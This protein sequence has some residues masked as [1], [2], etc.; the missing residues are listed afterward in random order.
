MVHSSGVRSLGVRSL[1]V[2]ILGAAAVIAASLSASPVVLAQGST[3]K[4]SGSGWFVPGAGA[5]GASG[6]SSRRV[7]EGHS[8]RS[9]AAEQA[10]AGQ[11][12][13]GQAGDGAPQTPPVLPLPP[14]PALPAM[15]KGTAPPSAV[16]GVLSVQDVMRASTA[17]QEVQRVL[18]ARRDKLNQEAEQEQAGWR[19]TQQQIQDSR[20][21]EAQKQKRERALQQRVL[22]AQR[23]FRNRNRILQEAAQV[24]LGQVE[25]EL[26]QVIR[27]VAEARGMNLVLHREQVALNVNGFD[28]TEQV[29]GQL[30]A[31]LNS[32]FIPGPG[33]DPE[34]MAKSGAFPTTVN[35][36]PQ[37]AA[38]MIAQGPASAQTAAATPR[39]Q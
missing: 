25:R 3:A 39:K 35:P 26:V 12:D 24:S 11:P 13:G 31:V 23:D 17:A 2:R 27:Q 36:G 18:G 16:I 30:N 5:S 4:S 21:S 38:P 15:Q 29:A 19:Q 22:S 1:G 28:I 34:E 6:A 14:I 9:P 10:D 32:V 7:P 8:F 33:V 20:G 37:P